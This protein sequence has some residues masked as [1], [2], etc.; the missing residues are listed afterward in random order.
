[1]KRESVFQTNLK[2]ELYKMFPG[3][4]ILRNDPNEIQGFP[5]LLIIFNDTWAMLECKK[6]MD[7]PYMPN[8]EYY[9]DELNRMS[10]A[11]M[12]CPENREEVLCELQRSFSIKRPTRFSRR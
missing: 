4:F 7:E 6:S 8:Q 10:F 9:I 11:A 2:K 12:I 1:M 5:D 3:C